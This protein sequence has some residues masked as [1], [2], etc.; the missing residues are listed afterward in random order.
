MGLHVDDRVGLERAIGWMR[1]WNEISLSRDH[2]FLYLQNL[3]LELGGD[4]PFRF[5]GEFQV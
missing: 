2:A 3:P 4:G 5:V 1:L